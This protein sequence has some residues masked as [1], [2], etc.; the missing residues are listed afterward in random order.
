MTVEPIS[1]SEGERDRRAGDRGAEVSE[2]MR[3]IPSVHELVEEAIGC[4]R[5]VW[6][7]A[8]PRDVVVDVVREVSG[9]FRAELLAGDLESCDSLAGRIDAELERASTPPLTSVINATGIILHTGLG[10]AP[11]ARDAVNVLAEVAAGYAPVEI[12]M[13]SG[14]RGKRSAIVRSLLGDLT[15]AESATVVNNN[16]AAMLLVFSILARGKEVIVS[17]GELVEIGGSFRIPDVIAASGA[18]LREVGTTN[19]TRLSDYAEGINENTAA[20]LKVH[21]SNYRIEGFTDEASVDELA[22]LGKTHGLPVIH[23]AG[24]GLLRPAVDYG[25]MLEDEPSVRESIDAGAD[26]VLFSGDK[27]LGG[28]QAGI[29]VGRG[30]LVEMM[31]RAPMMR[32]LRVDKLTYAALGAILHLHRDPREAAREVPGLRMATEAIEIV[33]ARADRLQQSVADVLDGVSIED[34][35]AYLGGGSVP[36]QGI[37]SVAVVIQPSEEGAWFTAGEFAAR[38]RS[39]SPSCRRRVMARVNQDGVWFD[40]RTVLKDDVDSLG[41]AIRAAVAGLR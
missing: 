41:E 40:L 19:K 31:E 33:R 16:A 2:L 18:I 8:L 38:L 24:S 1:H 15:G 32:A 37:E 3:L 36:G 10:R 27:L 4:R 9:E 17:R 20:L 6:G 14:K 34:S 26:L 21:T 22:G 28:P 29:I 5:G 13:E 12:E 25:L 30:E 39:G 11:I 23:D 35:T 7:R